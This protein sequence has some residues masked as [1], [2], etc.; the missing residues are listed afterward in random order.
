MFRNCKF[1]NPVR[2]DLLEDVCEFTVDKQHSKKKSDFIPAPLGCPRAMSSFGETA[3]SHA[4]LVYTSSHF[5]LKTIKK[6]KNKKEKA[7]MIRKW[8]IMD[9]T[10]FGSFFSI[11]HWDSSWHVGMRMIQVESPFFLY[12]SLYGQFRTRISKKIV[13]NF[14]LKRNNG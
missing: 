5:L 4:H 13:L 7:K 1:F 2:K 9:L 10:W 14:L 11:W 6:W 12:Y 8:Q 3:S